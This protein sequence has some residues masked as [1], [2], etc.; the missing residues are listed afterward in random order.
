MA[1]SEHKYER[2]VRILRERIEQR[3]Q[4]LKDFL[5]EDGRPMFYAKLTA[6]EE[7]SLYLNPVTRVKLEQSKL[8]IDGP[9]EYYKWK[10]QMEHR[11]YQYRKEISD[12]G[13]AMG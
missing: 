10:Q 1:K 9:E 6:K 5:S 11:A 4:L 2:R 12:G 13:T 7:L 8:T 3:I